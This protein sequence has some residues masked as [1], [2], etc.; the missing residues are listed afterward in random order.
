MERITD[1]ILHADLYYMLWMVANMTMPESATPGELPKAGLRKRTVHCRDE[2]L[3]QVVE[4][5]PDVRMVPET[6]QIDGHSHSVDGQMRFHT[7][8]KNPSVK[9]DRMII[10]WGSED[11]GYFRSEGPAH[12]ILTNLKMWHHQNVLHR[13]RGDAVICEHA[14]FSWNTDRQDPNQ[15]YRADGPCMVIMQKFRAD[16][17]RGELG[18]R[19]WAYDNLDV[20]WSVASGIRIA[21]PKIAAVVRDNKIKLDYLLT[22][23]VFLDDG[24]EFVF[25]DEIGKAQAA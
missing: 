12:I 3:P 21:S 8:N 13:R 14:N 23:S 9:A 6:I 11:E 24:E 2:W 22:G 18:G 16:M 20:T 7:G 17:K 15:A 19:R 1:Y 5:F 10:K 25:W 4:L